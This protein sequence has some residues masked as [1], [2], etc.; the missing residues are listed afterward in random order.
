[1]YT[2]TMTQP[3]PGVFMRQFLSSEVAEQG[4]QVAGPQHHP[5]AERRIRQ[6]VTTP[7][8]SELD[9]VKRAALFIA[10]N[11]L[12]IKDVVVIPVVYR[13]RVSAVA[14]QAARAAERLGQQLLGSAGL[15]PRCLMR[16]RR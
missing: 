7:S 2:T 8:D 14:K 16:Q 12:V 9:P 5:L 1:M 11:D 6:A 3:D 13:P 15:V 10:M 4:E